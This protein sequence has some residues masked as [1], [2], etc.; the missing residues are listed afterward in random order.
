M[1]KGTQNSND[2]MGRVGSHSTKGASTRGVVESGNYSGISDGLDTESRIKLEALRDDRAK[3][4]QKKIALHGARH[5]RERS[6]NIVELEANITAV[7]RKISE[8]LSSRIDW[9]SY[10]V[11]ALDELVDEDV[12]ADV[13][14][15]ASELFREEKLPKPLKRQSL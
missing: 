14:K 11:R 15:R 10:L 2:F 8:I 7:N 6:R 5:S 1:Y 12:K 9:G 13:I 4:V 3:L